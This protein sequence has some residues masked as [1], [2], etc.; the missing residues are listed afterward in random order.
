MAV[1]MAAKEEK[2]RAEAQE[3]L[4]ETEARLKAA[5]AAKRE[6]NPSRLGSPA[7]ADTPTPAEQESE[8]VSTTTKDDVQM[9]DESQPES[10]EPAEPEVNRKCGTRMLFTDLVY[11][12]GPWLPPLSA[13]FDDVKALMSMNANELIGYVTST[14][15]RSVPSYRS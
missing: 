15:G 4:E 3:R 11:L 8:P 9:T 6:P 2:A 12:Q 13:L 1:E 5:L 10:S 14:S 7:V